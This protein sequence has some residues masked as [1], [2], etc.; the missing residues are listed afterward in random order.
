MDLPVD[1]HCPSPIR[2]PEAEPFP[3]VIEG[4]GAPRGAARPRKLDGV[5]ITPN[6][7]ARAIEDL[8]RSGYR[9]LHARVAVPEPSAIPWARVAPRR[10]M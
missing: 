7:A 10:D 3:D 6:A 2:Q 5:R 8:R 9:P 1:A 4:G